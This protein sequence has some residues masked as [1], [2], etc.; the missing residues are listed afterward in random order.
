MLLQRRLI[1]IFVLLALSLPL[2]FEYS[3]PP[4]RMP[5]AE[6]AFKSVEDLKVA[7]GE[8][9]FVALDFGPST[10]AENESQALVL[11]EHLM[12]KRIPFA[13]FSYYFQAE[14]FLTSIPEQV[15]NKLEKEYPDQ[16]WRYGH[17]WV[18]L[19]YRPGAGMLIQA[20][21]KSEN[22]VQLFKKDAR[23]NS[24]EHIPAF[25][26][27]RT[28]KDIKLLL[29]ITSLTGVFDVYIQYFQAG[30]YKPPFIHGATSISVPGVF[31]YLDSGQL[32]G[33][34]EGISGA[35]WYSELLSKKYKDRAVDSAQVL[36]TSL[37]IA[38]L[39]IIFLILLGNVVAFVELYRRRQ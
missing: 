30:K 11:I 28:I 39:V 24:L 23:G 19:G 12:R 15:V 27:V 8:I 21:P 31:I 35:A 6:A 7:T 18:N 25:S 1:Y 38:H 4:A 32:N 14:P 34:L 29:E 5:A 17:D 13:L 3:S 33:L 9:A 20:I 26:K 10:K 37:G 16:V 36:N 2:I 22:L